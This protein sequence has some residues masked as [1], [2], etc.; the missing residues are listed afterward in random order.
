MDPHAMGNLYCHTNPCVGVAFGGVTGLGQSKIVFGG[1]PTAGPWANHR[2]HGSVN[3]STINTPINNQTKGGDSPRCN[4]SSA[5]SIKKFNWFCIAGCE[6]NRG[7][8]TSHQSQGV[9]FEF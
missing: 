3:T 9:V 1:A 2:H 8:I 7:R 5:N 6:N 4:I